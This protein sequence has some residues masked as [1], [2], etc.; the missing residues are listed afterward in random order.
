M[1]W[2]SHDQFFGWVHG[3]RINR[4][5]YFFGGRNGTNDRP[6]PVIINKPSFVQTVSNWN[7]ADT[8]LLL[9]FFVAGL[10]LARR[11]ALKDVL[12][13]SI[14]ERRADYKRYHRIITGFGLLL[15]LRNSSYRLE[16]FV[17][18]GLPK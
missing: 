10:F 5:N 9:S 14:V 6:Y 15:A 4:N 18:N 1:G 12:S 3:F 11:F 2:T 16:G 13:D 7:L 8:G 17:P